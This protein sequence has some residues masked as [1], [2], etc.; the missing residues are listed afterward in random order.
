[1]DFLK[2]LF[3]SGALTWEQFTEAVKKAGFQV[4]NAADGT[5]VPKADLDTKVRELE[6][7]NDTIKGLRE[8]AK[9][10]DGKDPQKLADDLKA[11][12]LK[13]D[14][15][16]ANIRRDAA[17]NLALTSARVKDIDMARAKIKLDDIKVDEKGGITGL[18]AQLEGLK[19]DKTWLFEDTAPAKPGYSPAGGSGTGMRNPWKKETFNLTEQGRIFR[20]DPAQAKEMM[21]AAGITTE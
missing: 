7:A 3:T 21:A 4:V 12:Q 10:W 20:A 6:T 1:M 8:T 5:Y 11:L 17:I 15:D 2:E 18:D 14:T 19:K 9:K 16:T 13:Y